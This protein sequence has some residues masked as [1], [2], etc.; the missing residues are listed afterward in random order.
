MKFGLYVAKVRK[1]PLRLVVF[2][3]QT[4]KI[5]IIWEK[6]GFTLKFKPPYLLNCWVNFDKISF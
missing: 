2:E 6:R 1:T 5:S 3:I 4:F